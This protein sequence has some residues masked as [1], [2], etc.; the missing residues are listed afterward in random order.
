MS[1]KLA[2][3]RAA[4]PG[5]DPPRRR[6]W[7]SSFSFSVLFYHHQAYQGK[8]KMRRRDQ[9]KGFFQ[10][11]SKK[12]SA[13]HSASTTSGATVEPRSN[14]AEDKAGESTTSGAAVESRSN[15]PEDKACQAP[16][17]GN[18]SDLW[19]LALESLSKE[20]KCAVLGMKLDSKLDILRYLYTAARTKQTECE[21]RSWKFKLHDRQIILRDVAGKIIAWIDRFKQIGD[22]A[23]QYDPVHASL[24]WAGIRFL[25]EVRLM[26]RPRQ[27]H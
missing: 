10:K 21:A 12:A 2:K 6:T 8:Y 5:T 26:M 22:I 9:F 27:N 16:L 20:D 18:R 11:P 24:P 19:G 13:S 1:Y 15:E 14:E 23:V 3:T 7:T 4:R 25:L 17:T